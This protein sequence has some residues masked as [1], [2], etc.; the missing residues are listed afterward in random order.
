MA[1]LLS[2]SWEGISPELREI[3]ERVCTQ[4]QIDCLRLYAQGLGYRRIGLVLEIDESVVRHHLRAGRLNIQREVA[5]M[6]GVQ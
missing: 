6:R 2:A 1:G 5:A 4:R 3:M